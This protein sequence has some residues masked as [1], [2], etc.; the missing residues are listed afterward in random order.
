MNKLYIYIY[1]LFFKFPPHLIHH[2]ALSRAPCVIQQVLNGIN[3]VHMSIP[4]LQFIPAPLLPWHPCLL[5]IMLQWT[6]EGMFLFKLWFYPGI[7]PVVGL[8]GHMVVLF[9]VFLRKLQAILPFWTATCKRMKLGHSLIS[10]TN[11][12]SEWIK[13]LNVGLD[14]MILLEENTGRTLFT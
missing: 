4:I 7:C 2:R 5:Y 3:G 10:S 14:T 6:L 1:P 9:L 12:K 13:D 11:I 8:L